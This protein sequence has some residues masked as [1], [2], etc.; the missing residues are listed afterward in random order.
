MFKFRLI[1][2]GLILTALF[3]FAPRASAQS[4]F[5]DRDNLKD[6]STY[7]SP[8]NLSES[9]LSSTYNN[10]AQAVNYQTFCQENLFQ[11]QKTNLFVGT[12]CDLGSIAAIS[13]ADFATNATC[14]IQKVAMN[15]Y[16]HSII[17]TS[18]ANG[19]NT[20]SGYCVPSH[21]ANTT[22]ALAKTDSS[23][24]FGKGDS[25]GTG[26]NNTGLYAPG[27]KS[28]LSQDILPDPAS[29]TWI[30]SGYDIVRNFATIAAFIFLLIFA[31]ANILHLDVNTYTIKKMIPNIIIAVVGAYLSIYAIFL[32][33]RGVDFLYR[34]EFFSPYNSLHPFYSI[35]GGNFGSVVNYAQDQNL[36]ALALIYQLGGQIL[37]GSPT[38]SILSGIL[39]VIFL[40]IPAIVVFAFE[41]VLALRPIVVGLLVIVSP[42]AFAAYVFPAGQ[43]IFRKW[44]IFTA[45]A[46]MYTPAVN[47][48]L[49]VIN[50]LPIPQDQPILFLLILLVKTAVLV[51]LMRM[52]FT[53]ETDIQKISLA[54]SKTSLGASLG[55]GKAG[56]QSIKI[57]QDNKPVSDRILE[58]R[59]AKSLIAPTSGNY[60]R[61]LTESKVETRTRQ[62]TLTQI[63]NRP[64]GPVIKNLE[65]VSDKA[66]TNN[67]SRGANLLVNSIADLSPQALRKIVTSSNIKIFKDPPLIKEL[68]VKNG[69]LLDDEGAVTRA[70]AGKKVF[71]VAQLVEQGKIGNPEAVK[72][73][74][75][76]QMLDV[77]P[78]EILKRS[79]EQ[80]VINK[81]DI[82]ANFKGDPEK[83]ITR[84]SEFNRGRVLNTTEIR[85]EIEKDHSDSKTGFTD[86]LYALEANV[87]QR[88]ADKT[89]A[90]NSNTLK[91]I[92][93]LKD[94]DTFD[95]NGLYYLSRLHE[96]NDGS[97][98]RL[99][100]SLKQAGTPAQTAIAISRNPALNYDQ[101]TSYV[102]E[103]ARPETLSII[104]ESIAERDISQSMTREIST[105]LK[106][107][108]VVLGSAVAEKIAS[109]L[110]QGKVRSF[111]DA[112][113]QISTS[114]KNLSTNSNPEEVKS[115]VGQ[116]NS[117]APFAQIQTDTAPTADDVEKIKNKG[118]VVLSTIDEMKMAGIDEKALAEDPK[119]ATEKYSAKVQQSISDV[120]SGQIKPEEVL[121]LSKAAAEAGDETTSAQMPQTPSQV[122]ETM[123]KIISTDA[124][125]GSSFEQKLTNIAANKPPAEKPKQAQAGA[126]NA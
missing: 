32:V 125:G 116:L 3:A 50:L 102:P 12:F 21:G 80:G 120:A 93:V 108:K 87:N 9:V 72:V 2:L 117:F 70:D 31:F 88:P 103:S 106:E 46:L 47:L 67:L 63:F 51:L 55:L 29:P 110:N 82:Q 64:Q 4:K 49:Y 48:V 17:F 91:T 41:Y 8:I 33:S 23:N 27:A 28:Q 94:Q 11:F 89:I 19:S 99:E 36:N 75:Q 59:A 25:A 81:E 104:R 77:L 58:S 122:T 66:H 76:K 101:I 57:K 60:R 109:A 22:T 54:L 83:A 37:G 7:Q 18:N 95:Q 90:T 111:D 43:N 14:T 85:K 69:Q 73:L 56:A 26:Q 39:G 68:K 61:D 74:S 16:D 24:I 13:A 65:E 52:P 1:I 53:I 119:K 124:K 97:K 6:W 42:L 71:R 118:E 40:S 86:L 20:T 35:M 114:L 126:K 92:E 115:A 15:N 98:S 84:I 112:K 100:T 30:K 96:I 113:G 10:T 123:G 34:L 107:D 38:V 44:V 45:I 105:S 5:N 78:L 121:D 79:L 62:K